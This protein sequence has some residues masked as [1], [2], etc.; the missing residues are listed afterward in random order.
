MSAGIQLPLFPDISN[1]THFPLPESN[2][3]EFKESLPGKDC[4]EKQVLLPICG[5]L[6][7]SGGY[8]VL[9]VVDADRSIKGV[10]TDKKL[11][12]FLLR[13]DDIIRHQHIWTSAEESY[14]LPENMNVQLIRTDEDKTLVVVKV[15][16][17]PGK[18]YYTTVGKVIRLSASNLKISS[19]PKYIHSDTFN[20][21]AEKRLIHYKC[22]K[23]RMKYEHQF[24]LERLSKEMAT[25]VGMAKEI[26][27]KLQKESQT[28]QKTLEELEKRILLDKEQ[29]EEELSNTWFNKILSLLCLTC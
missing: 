11:D 29:K 13:M 9:G 12:A 4:F 28:H 24:E 22:E 20:K 14:V 8:L 5:F 17:T 1:E 27:A 2:W 25:L 10:P 26:E 23:L 21:M 16:P 7:A 3:L 18:E 15:V 19:L 6:N